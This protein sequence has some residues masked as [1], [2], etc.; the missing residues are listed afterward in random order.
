VRRAQDQERVGGD[1]RARADEV[2]RA[3]EVEGAVDRLA[4]LLDVLETAE[5]PQVQRQGERVRVPG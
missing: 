4:D 1:R 5:V 3:V 2:L